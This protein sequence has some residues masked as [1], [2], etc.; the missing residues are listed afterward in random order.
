MVFALF[1]VMVPT[2]LI[3]AS[4]MRMREQGKHKQRADKDDNISHNLSSKTIGSG[5]IHHRKSA[6]LL[7]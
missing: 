1:P 2:L 5:M 4:T 6:R 3:Q 7:L